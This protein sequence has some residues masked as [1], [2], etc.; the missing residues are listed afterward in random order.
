M[1]S[2]DVISWEW[3][4]EGGSPATS[5]FQNPQVMY[6]T[7]GTYDV[8]LTVSDGVDTH[9]VTMDDYITVDVCSAVEESNVEN[10]SVYPN[11][12]NGIFTVEFANVPEDNVTIKVLNTLG[13]MIYKE[14][15]IIEGDFSRTLDLSNFD[16]GMYFLVLENYQGNTVNR[17][18]I[19]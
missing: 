6:S 5:S 18:I 8:T 19:R 9:S 15:L 16:K 10:I 14:N 2:G 12:N 13:T 11:P 7:A 17:I 4:F 1:S 3:E